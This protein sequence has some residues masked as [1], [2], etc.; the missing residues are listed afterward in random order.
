MVLEPVCPLD[1]EP[2]RIGAPEDTI[3]V[4]RSPN[5]LLRQNRRKGSES[6]FESVLAMSVDDRQL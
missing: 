3:D 4:A 6:A 1:G 5:K 2:P